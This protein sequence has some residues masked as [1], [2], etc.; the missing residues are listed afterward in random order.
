MSTNLPEELLGVDEVGLDDEQDA[1]VR[2]DGEG[3]E[4]P[5]EHERVLV[6]KLGEQ[7]YGLDVADVRSI[8]EVGE[9]TRVPR[10]SE[11]V[12]GVMDLRGEITAVIDPGVLLPVSSAAEG[13]DTQRVVVFD[14]ASDKQSAGIR[15]DA[16]E[17]VES[18]PVS[19]IRRDEPEFQMP[20]G[21]L[22]KAVVEIPPE[23]DD[24]DAPAERISVIDADLLVESAG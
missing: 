11:A 13:E 2:E 24:A 1:D 6:F 4:E 18:F 22:V 20:A 12:E 21:D 17:G 14:R 3:D 8:V 23:D 10:S 7:S 15:V 5:E 9:R 19:R 16:V